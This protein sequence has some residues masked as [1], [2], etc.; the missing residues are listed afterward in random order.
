MIP[1][2]AVLPEAE[3][4]LAGVYV[5]SMSIHDAWLGFESLPVEVTKGFLPVR[6]WALS[7]TRFAGPITGW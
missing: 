6:K 4:L 5:E 3:P 1:R 7:T 2:L